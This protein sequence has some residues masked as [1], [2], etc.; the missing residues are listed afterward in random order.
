[1]KVMT[2]ARVK[3]ISVGIVAAVAVVVI[4]FLSLISYANRQD[5]ELANY[6]SSIAELPEVDSV[7]STHR[8]N[9][10]ESYVVAGVVL[11]DGQEFYYFVRD[12]TVQEY[13]A[14][15]DLIG[16]SR[17]RSIAYEVAAEGQATAFM[18]VQ[19]GTIG[20][21]A[22]FEARVEHGGRIHYVV[23]DALDGEI[24]MQFDMER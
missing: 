17:A 12:G 14:R 5:R 21:R 23:M 15:D 22:I 7:V 8:F 6:A 3:W 13:V 1:M 20:D 19:L 18:S 11:S 24:I 2:K 9:G 4:Y 10:L 16:E